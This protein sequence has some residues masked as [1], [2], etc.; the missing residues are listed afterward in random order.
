[1]ADVKL[2][3]KQLKNVL[4]EEGQ[5]VFEKHLYDSAFGQVKAEIKLRLDAI[6]KHVRESLEQLDS[7]QKDMQS[8]LVREATRGNAPVE[9]ANEVPKED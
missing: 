3:R 4:E 1:M 6:E 9:Q 5:K 7:R 8:F 2:I